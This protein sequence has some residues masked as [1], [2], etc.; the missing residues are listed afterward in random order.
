[1]AG[2]V[3]V[4]VAFLLGVSVHAGDADPAGAVY[5]QHESKVIK[6][7][8][9][10]TRAARIGNFVFASGASAFIDEEDKE[11]AIDMATLEAQAAMLDVAFEEVA[12]P[13]KIPLSLRWELWNHYRANSHQ[14]SVRDVET[15]SVEE[16]DGVLLVIVG[17]PRSSLDV[18]IP[19]YRDLVRKIE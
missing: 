4:A 9:G 7:L 17:T 10:R 5:K 3:A 11:H 6:A 13:D 15:I 1:M 16:G 14:F 8:S 2:L 19:S 18:A 12:W